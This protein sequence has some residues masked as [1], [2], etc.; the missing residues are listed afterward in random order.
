MTRRWGKG[1]A[2]GRCDLRKLSRAGLTKLSAAKARQDRDEGAGERPYHIAALAVGAAERML[3]DAPELSI[4]RKQFRDQ[5]IAEFQLSA[6]L[7]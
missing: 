3:R 7:I 2:H 1:R 4:D 5:P 6:E